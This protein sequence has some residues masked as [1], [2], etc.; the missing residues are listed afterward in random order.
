MFLQSP[1]VSTYVQ[2]KEAPVPRKIIIGLVVF[3][4]GAMAQN[5]LLRASPPI[6]AVVQTWSYDPQTNVVTLK[7]ANTSHKD[8]T[9]F[10]ITHKETYA[11]GRVEQGELLEELMGKIII[12][13]EIQGNTSRGAENFRKM[14]GDGAFHPGEV[15]DEIVGAQPGFQKIEALV[16]V[17]TYADATAEATNNDGLGRIIDE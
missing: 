7:I 1:H 11:D 2:L 12:A 15:R 14:H 17:V 5:S 13:K 8:I 16:D 3:A 6:G 9:A 4:L 10:N